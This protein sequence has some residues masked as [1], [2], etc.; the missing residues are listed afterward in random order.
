MELVP[1]KRPHRAAWPLAPRE[2]RTRSLRSEREP[3]PHHAGTLI[4]DSASRTARRHFWFIG[5]RTVAF[6]YS[7]LNAV[8]QFTGG[9]PIESR[10]AVSPASE[11]PPLS[12]GASN[13]ARDT[14]LCFLLFVQTGLWPKG[15]L[16]AVWP[17]GPG[18]SQVS[19]SLVG[20]PLCPP[21]YL[22]NLTFPC[23][24][25]AL[26]LHMVGAAQPFLC[27]T[28]A[29]LG[30]SINCP[31]LG[32]PAVSKQGFHLQGHCGPPVPPF[33]CPPQAHSRRGLQVLGCPSS[34][35][36][37][38]APDGTSSCHPAREQDTLGLGQRPLAE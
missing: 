35:Y 2:D 23:L 33:L 27:L 26:V 17:E 4:S 7:D 25:W 16:A 22:V 11:A 31:H 3:S 13:N 6:C 10:A 21:A 12:Q 14:G 34:T 5:H 20:L 1:Y 8:R 38:Q 15:T 36:A 28:G 24:P 9:I 18:Q 29:A 19:P 30:L 32:S 37:M